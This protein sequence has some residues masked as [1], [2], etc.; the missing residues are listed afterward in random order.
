MKTKL[1]E[2]GKEHDI[3]KVQKAVVLLLIGHLTSNPLLILPVVTALFSYFQH[4]FRHPFLLSNFMNSS[5]LT[6]F[7]FP[8]LSLPPPRRCLYSEA[9]CTS[10]YL[11]CA[12]KSGCCMRSGYA[13]TQLK[14]VTWKQRHE[15][16]FIKLSWTHNHGGVNCFCAH[17]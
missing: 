1:L 4:C 9:L 17:G 5:S 2:D 14:W 12:H 6:W 3:C 10:W 7:L 16:L 13:H 8:P 15:I 11:G